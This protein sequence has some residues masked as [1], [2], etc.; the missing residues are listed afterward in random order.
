MKVRKHKELFI[1]SMATEQTIDTTWKA[2]RTWASDAAQP[3]TY[4]ALSI[5]PYTHDPR[6][7]W[8]TTFVVLAVLNNGERCIVGFCDSE[9]T[10]RS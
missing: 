7:G 5:Q 4:I 9:I 6:T 2:L 10:S 1:E 8:D 3:N